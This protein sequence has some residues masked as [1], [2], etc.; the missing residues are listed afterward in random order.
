MARRP[1]RHPRPAAAVLRPADGH[2]LPVRSAHRRLRRRPRR[3]GRRLRH[4]VPRSVGK[5]LRVGTCLLNDNPP[6]ARRRLPARANLAQHVQSCDPQVE[7]AIPG[8]QH[9]LSD[10]CT[11]VWTG[12]STSMGCC[13]ATAGRR[14]LAALELNGRVARFN[15]YASYGLVEATFESPLELPG[16]DEANDAATEDGSIV[17][18]PGDRLP[19]RSPPQLQGGRP[20]GN[21]PVTHGPLVGNQEAKWTR[22]TCAR[23]W[24]STSPVP[25]GGCGV[26]T[27][28]NFSRSCDG[29]VSA[30]S[31]RSA[32]S[33]SLTSR[34]SLCRRGD[35]EG[36]RAT[37]RPVGRERKWRTRNVRAVTLPPQLWKRPAVGFARLRKLP[38]LT[39]RRLVAE[40]R[41]AMERG[42]AIPC[43]RSGRGFPTTA[44]GDE[45]IGSGGATH[46]LR[47]RQRAGFPE[48]A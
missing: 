27:P 20:P 13:S 22:P 42:F 23:T 48:P 25:A 41:F 10:A 47:P 4:S 33:R 5:R 24:S 19:R 1:R 46:L 35:P 44:V 30:S 29:C 16:S 37:D 11:P 7:D 12:P 40:L 2:R 26:T 28:A 38:A 6:S 45:P 8:E 43:R 3:L 31:S 32:S 21:H 14:R 34:S 17:V 18:E 39:G 9:R 15:W 36:H